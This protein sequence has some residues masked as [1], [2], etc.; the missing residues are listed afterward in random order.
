MIWHIVR[1]EMESLDET[2]RVELE[3]ELRALA[4]IEEVAWL[5][6]SRDIDEPSVTGLITG[7]RDADAL[8]V[9]RTHPDHL[10][11]LERVR[12]HGVAATRLDIATEDDAND[13]P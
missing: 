13:L 5:R 12:A 11:V 2:A 10:P 3:D 8:D 7:F 1:F 6:V 9:Y 4:R